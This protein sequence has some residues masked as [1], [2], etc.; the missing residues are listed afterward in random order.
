[1]FWSEL[2]EVNM[3]MK[4]MPRYETRKYCWPLVKP[5][6]Y[7]W[8]MGIGECGWQVLWLSDSERS[9]GNLLMINVKNLYGS[10]IM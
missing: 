6:Y 2:K 8:D 10:P 1:M 3:I 7:N 4:Q 5:F 9:A